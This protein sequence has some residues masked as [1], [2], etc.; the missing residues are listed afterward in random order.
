M[1]KWFSEKQITDQTLAIPYPYT[2]KDAYGY[3]EYIKTS[4]GLHLAIRT[5]EG[6][7]IGGIGLKPDDKKGEHCREIGY[8]LAKPYWGKGIT[9]E[10]VKK[11]CEYGFKELNLVRIEAPIFA[12]NTASIRVVE[13]AGFKKEELMKK[14]YVKNGEYIDGIMYAITK[15]ATSTQRG[16]VDLRVW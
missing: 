11:L 6:L 10:A 5:N 13:K 8:W 3:L 12:F 14:A 7:F 4:K 15:Q 9:T 1:V 16:G 2:E